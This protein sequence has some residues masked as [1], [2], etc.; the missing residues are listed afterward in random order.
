MPTYSRLRADGES[1]ANPRNGDDNEMAFSPRYMIA[2]RYP[3]SLCCGDIEHNFCLTPEAE[4]S[5]EEAMMVVFME[6]E[7]PMSWSDLEY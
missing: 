4:K 2:S 5:R 3:C 6:T 7:G 1:R